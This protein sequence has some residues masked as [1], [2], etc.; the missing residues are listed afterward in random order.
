M[1]I[2]NLCR[3]LIL[4]PSWDFHTS[5]RK[6]HENPSFFHIF[7]PCPVTFSSRQSISKERNEALF[8]AASAYPRPIRPSDGNHSGHL[9]EVRLHGQGNPAITQHPMTPQECQ[10]KLARLKVHYENRNLKKFAG[11]STWPPFMIRRKKRPRRPGPVSISSNSP[12]SPV[13]TRWSGCG[14]AKPPL[15]AGPWANACVTPMNGKGP[16]PGPSCRRT[17]VLT[18]PKGFLPIRPSSG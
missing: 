8:E 18:W 17:I 7:G 12:I 13:L 11:P 2:L 4:N 1:I 9:Q 5:G 15:S 14:P 16:V 3:D 10:E 6:V